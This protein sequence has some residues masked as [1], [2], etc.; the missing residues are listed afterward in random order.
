MPELEPLREPIVGGVPAH[1]FLEL[2]QGCA[3]VDYEQFCA[4]DFGPVAENLDPHRSA[5]DSVMGC[6][7]GE[8]SGGDALRRFEPWAQLTPSEFDSRDSASKY[9]SAP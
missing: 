1:L 8:P 9:E 7:R 2:T 6:S 5:H 3:V 4:G